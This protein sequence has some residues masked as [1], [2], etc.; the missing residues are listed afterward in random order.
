[1]VPALFEAYLSVPTPLFKTISCRDGSRDRTPSP[2]RLVARAH[3]PIYHIVA[4][5]CHW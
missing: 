3:L 2:R 4:S 5:L 1:M